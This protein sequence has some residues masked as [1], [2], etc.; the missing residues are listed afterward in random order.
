METNRETKYR[1]TENDCNNE[2]EKIKPQALKPSRDCCFSV[3]SDWTLGLTK[4]NVLYFWGKDPTFEGTISMETNSG[5]S[6]YLR[7]CTP[8][9]LYN[10]LEEKVKDITIGLDHCFIITD[11]C[12]VYTR[13]CNKSGQ[14]GLGHFISRK[15]LEL[16]KPPD[17]QKWA[18][19]SAGNQH[20]IAITQ[21]GELYFWGNARPSIE[22]VTVRFYRV[23]P[24]GAKSKDFL[25]TITDS[26]LDGCYISPTQI[27]TPKEYPRWKFV[28]AGSWH[29][30]AI[31]EDGVLFGC[32]T[33]EYKTIDGIQNE[34]ADF[35]EKF[36]KIVTSS[37]HSFGFAENG[38]VY[39]WG[40][41]DDGQLGIGKKKNIMIKGMG[42]MG[43]FIPQELKPPKDEQWEVI[44][45]GYDL[46][47]AI[48]KKKNIY[49]WG[50]GAILHATAS[51]NNRYFTPQ[52]L[53]PYKDEKWESIITRQNHS[54][55][56]TQ[57]A[58]VYT[59]GVG[60]QGQQGL[61]TFK[62]QISPNLLEPPKGE[63]W[64]VHCGWQI[65]RLLF[66]LYYKETD[67]PFYKEKIPMD[68]WKH[69]IK[70]FL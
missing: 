11:T 32:G 20:S 38:K 55:A 1:K 68:V 4:K 29:G 59:W 22:C 2:D 40:R 58:K 6:D 26:F 44:N 7:F 34:G 57:N 18:Q 50:R 33:Y 47:T 69:I 5:I 16:L 13:G 28:T 14:L 10:F 8:I 46:S 41:N 56:I 42:P 21:S 70:S 27:H 39:A 67:S 66:I 65:I 35:D 19:I 25:R 15:N 61:G 43:L 52:L 9:S 36:K 53:E 62:D 30:F 45:A 51:V 31:N 63:E 49:I 64:N 17:K 3:G 48:T 60:G 23:F 54:I 12:N 24:F 37:T